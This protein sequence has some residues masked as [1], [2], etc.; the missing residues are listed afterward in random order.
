[1]SGDGP[2]ITPHT[3]ASLVLTIFIVFAGVGA[4]IAHQQTESPVKIDKA[5]VGPLELREN[6]S[7]A[8]VYRVNLTVTNHADSPVTVGVWTWDQERH[9]YAFWPVDGGHPNGTVTLAP[10]ETRELTARALLT[11]NALNPGRPA[12]VVLM[13]PD[14]IQRTAT[15]VR[16]PRNS[17]YTPN[18]TEGGAA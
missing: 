16:T 7:V 5:E 10:G 14:G 17:T 12:S 11:R 6:A 8:A 18:G 9:G 3:K 2:E 15:T 13:T 1:M 4:V